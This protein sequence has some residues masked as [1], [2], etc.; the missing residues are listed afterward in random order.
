MVLLGCEGCGVPEL[1]RALAG[2]K[3]VQLAA[4]EAKRA[5]DP[6][7]AVP[8]SDARCAGF[9][10]FRLKPWRVEMVEGGPSWPEGPRRV[11]WRKID[12]Q[13]YSL[14]GIGS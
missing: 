2:S 4:V 1:S 11:E 7:R 10:C 8:L 3:L 13:K 5:S 9:R 6:N 14:F 12:G